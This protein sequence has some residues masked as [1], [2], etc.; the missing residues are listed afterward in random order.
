MKT[1]TLCLNEKIQFL[2][3]NSN[4]IGKAKQLLGL[5]KISTNART[6]ALSVTFGFYLG[7]FP[8]VGTTTMLCLFAA[9]IFRLNHLM[10]QLVNWLVFPL[11][12]L[13]IIPFYKAGGVFFVS[14]AP[15]VAAQKLSFSG[16]FSPGSIEAV[17]G[18]VTSAF[19]G[20][21]VW[22]LFTVTTFYFV[23]MIV[24][25]VISRYFNL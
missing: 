7:V 11:Q 24:L 18:I 17:K 20:I 14:H 5:I 12:L 23:Y 6:T 13:F 3:L 21:V 22:G 8:I 19:G 1:H 10:I 25:T 16:L 9:L 4:Y 2:I 15:A